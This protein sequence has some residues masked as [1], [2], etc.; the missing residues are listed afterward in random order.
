MTTFEV[1]TGL[2][3]GHRHQIVPSA[4]VSK[5]LRAFSPV[6]AGARC[7][8]MFLPSKFYIHKENDQLIEF[9]E[10]KLKLY[11]SCSTLIILGFL[12]L[13]MVFVNEPSG[14]KAIIF[15]GNGN[16]KSWVFSSCCR[17]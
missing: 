17:N 12:C 1:Y 3:K 14:W 4:L 15:T 5:P 6:M 16:G 8:C 2:P 9:R 7:L 10:K 11:L 13:Y